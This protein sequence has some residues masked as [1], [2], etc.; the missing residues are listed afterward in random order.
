MGE[1]LEVRGGPLGNGQ[2][3]SSSFWIFCSA[4]PVLG[5]VLVLA[6]M[7]AS[8]CFSCRSCPAARL[9]TERWGGS[10]QV[11]GHPGGLA[12]PHRGRKS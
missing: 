4:C 2:A 11:P 5:P 6:L 1:W 8:A 9:G 12:Q 3:S 7:R 10:T